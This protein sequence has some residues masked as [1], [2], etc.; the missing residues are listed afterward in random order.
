MLIFDLR[1]WLM[2][3]PSK[4]KN[5]RR[6]REKVLEKKEEKER[7]D[8]RRIVPGRQRSVANECKAYRSMNNY[9]VMEDRG[10]NSA[11]EENKLWL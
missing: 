11:Q 1:V 8:E 3:F 10:E 2:I 6:V 9:I 5:E 7:M 4:E